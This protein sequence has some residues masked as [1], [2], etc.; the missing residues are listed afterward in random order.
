MIGSKKK[1]VALTSLN[2]MEILR[3][4]VAESRSVG[5]HTKK[6]DKNKRKNLTNTTLTSKKKKDKR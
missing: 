6:S 5:K 4:D 2:M 3:K 1:K